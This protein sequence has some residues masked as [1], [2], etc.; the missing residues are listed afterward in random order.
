MIKLRTA[1]AQDAPALSKIYKY[2]VENTTISF[3]YDAPT[4]EEFAE[5][6]THKLEKYPFIVAEDNGTVVG[7]SYASEYRERRAYDHSVELSIYVDKDERHCGIGTMLYSALLSLLSEQNFAS[8][9]SCITIPNSPSVS[10][11]EEMGFKLIGYFHKAGFKHG[12]WL[13]VAWY[14]R[15]LSSY[16]HA[17]LEIIPFPNLDKN[18]IEEILSSQTRNS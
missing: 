12:A 10:F 3:E 4:T 16:D 6:V 13:D 8:A 2:Y 18:K 11:H 9:Y 15:A 1:T 7:Y 14:E 5:R 17:P